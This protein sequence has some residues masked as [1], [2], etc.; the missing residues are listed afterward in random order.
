MFEGGVI[1]PENL[2]QHGWYIVDIVIEFEDK[3][4]P[5]QLSF[6]VL[7]KVKSSGGIQPIEEP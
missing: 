6:Y 4:Y 5:E 2:W 7:G 3:F 1:V